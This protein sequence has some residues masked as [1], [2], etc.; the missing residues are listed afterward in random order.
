MKQS[1]KGV[2]LFDF[3]GVIS[4]EIAPIWF[5]KHFD[6]E[7]AIRLKADI[8]VPADLGLISEEDTYIKMQELSGIPAEEIKRDFYALININTELL[9]HIR[10]LRE[11]YKVYIISNA[12]SSFLRKILEDY[13]LY[14]YFDGVFISAEMKIAKPD[15]KYFDYVL[16][17]IGFTPE[18]AI[19]TDDNPKNVK[20]AADAGIDGIIFENTADFITKLYK[21][22]G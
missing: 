11:N 5:D 22:L 1:K 12:S 16:D 21:M 9:S 2:L 17:K 3:F 20:A 4:T 10:A 8:F 15:T 14:E 13:S 19:M 7:S 18:E 6:S